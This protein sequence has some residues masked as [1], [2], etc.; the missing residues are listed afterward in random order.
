[1]LKKAHKEDGK[2]IIKYNFKISW[3]DL[4]KMEFF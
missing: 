2:E 1:M 3:E 4:V